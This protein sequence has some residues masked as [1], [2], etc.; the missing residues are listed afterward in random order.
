MAEAKE[1][2]PCVIRLENMMPVS[3]SFWERSTW[4]SCS[5]A[6][7][8]PAICLCQ[9]QEANAAGDE[10][11]IGSKHHSAALPPR[12]LYDLQACQGGEMHSL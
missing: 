6:M 2:M 10:E 12:Q 5:L 3:S 11:E 9:V 1:M 4:I 8:L 7:P